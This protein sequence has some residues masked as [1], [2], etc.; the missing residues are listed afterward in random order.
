MNF[1]ERLPGHMEYLKTR[2]KEALAER[3]KLRDER[4]G[5][6]ERELDEIEDEI[7][8]AENELREDFDYSRLSDEIKAIEEEHKRLS[9]YRRCE[10][11][12]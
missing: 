8:H 7:I 11:V 3:D 2:H 1:I 4:V 9:M 6:L 10:V 12:V 5:K